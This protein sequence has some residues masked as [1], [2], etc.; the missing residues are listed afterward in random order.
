MYLLATVVLV[1]I[2]TYGRG[3]ETYSFRGQLP[4]QQK[5]NVAYLTAYFGG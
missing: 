2:N 3:A 5:V 1:S 4:R